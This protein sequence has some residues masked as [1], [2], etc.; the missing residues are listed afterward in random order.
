MSLLS[1]CITGG[2][3]TGSF[4]PTA[5]NTCPDHLSRSH[6]RALRDNAAPG[7]WVDPKD[8]QHIIA[9]PADGV[10]Q[11]GRIEE[12]LD[13]GRTWKFA[14]EGMKVP[15]PRHMVERFVQAGDYLFAILSNGELLLKPLKQSNWQPVLPEISRVKAMAAVIND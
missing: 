5:M 9:G 4:M 15:W 7:A 12:S 2:P 11:N 14:S 6:W 3:S 10:S 1:T 8:S 13:G